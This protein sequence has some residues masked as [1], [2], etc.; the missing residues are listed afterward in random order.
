[1]LSQTLIQLKQEQKKAESLQKAASERD[2]YE[3]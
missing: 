3:Q 1:M 2:F